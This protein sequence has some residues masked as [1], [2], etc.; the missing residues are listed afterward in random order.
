M[1]RKNSSE[2]NKES[3]YN[4]STKQIFTECF[5]YGISSVLKNALL[6]A[7]E[8]LD[9]TVEIPNNSNCH[10]L[11]SSKQIKQLLRA[12]PPCRDLKVNGSISVIIP[13]YNEENNMVKTLKS[14]FNNREEFNDCLEIII[15]DG[16]SSDNTV[17]IAKTFFNNSEFKNYHFVFGGYNRATSQNIGAQKSNGDIILFLHADSILPYNWIQDVRNTMSIQKN[18]GGCFEF[19]MIL[20]SD[21]NNHDNNIDDESSSSSILGSNVFKTLSNTM[22]SL[23]SRIFVNILQKSTNFR[24]RYFL[25]P[26]GDQALFFRK[27][28]FFDY[29]NRFPEVQLLEDL[30]LIKEMRKYGNISTI[31]KPVETSARRWEINGFLWNTFLNQVR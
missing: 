26:Y 24:S 21:Q 1:S 25:L 2:E 29:F 12:E 3:I 20:S 11:H 17:N 18:L 23:W 30:I 7:Q 13:T 15:S 22:T 8:Y 10:L 16:G 9:I 5:Y 19:K 6:M 28:I 4:P 27:G 31:P 14:V